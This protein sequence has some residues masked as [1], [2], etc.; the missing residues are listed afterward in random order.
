MSGQLNRRAGRVVEILGTSAGGVGVHVQSLVGHLTDDGWPVTVAAPSS[1]HEVFDFDAVGAELAVVPIRGP[2]RELLAVPAVRRATRDAAIVHAHGLRAGTAAVLSRKTHRRT[3]PQR[4]TPLVVTWHNAVLAKGLTGRL[5]G[6][7]ERFVARGAD[8][9]LAASSDLAERIRALGGRDVRLVPVAPPS[10]VPNRDAVDVR[11]ELA[12]GPGAALVVCVARLHPQKGLDVL[13]RAASG[14]PRRTVVVIAGD[15]PLHGALQAQIDA[16]HAPVRLLGRRD[17]VADLLGAADLVVLPSRW[18]ARPLAVQEAMQLARPVVATDV[19]GVS[20]LIGDGAV[21]V[22]PDD[23]D[24]LAAAI[25]GLLTDE[26][27]RMELARRAAAVAA[28]WPTEA[29]SARAVVAVY[30]G[31]LGASNGETPA[32]GR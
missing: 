22:P 5:L 13:I 10:P 20:G 18:E 28:Q 6:L 16:A 31:L 9:N 11:A 29:D 19:G 21:L 14:L 4:P 32:R 25:G 2:G 8:V 23:A 15:G 1:T 27:R 17:D 3:T 24:A 7:G 26:T 12:V 30:R